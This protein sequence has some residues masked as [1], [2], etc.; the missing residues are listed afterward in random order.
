MTECLRVQPGVD[1]DIACAVGSGTHMLRERAIMIRHLAG[2]G[3]RK[4]RKQ[5]YAWALVGIMVERSDFLMKMAKLLNSNN[6][7]RLSCLNW[8]GKC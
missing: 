2:A 6:P 1:K 3:L 5:S 8:L 7:Y 4:L